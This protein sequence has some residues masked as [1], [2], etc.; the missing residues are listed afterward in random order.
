[1]CK[2]IPHISTRYCVWC[3]VQVQKS[4]MWHEW[5][6]RQHREGLTKCH[7]P[8]IP[9]LYPTS[10]R[11]SAIVVSFRGSP[12]H[13][14]THNTIFTAPTLNI[15]CMV[16]ADLPGRLGQRLQGRC[17]TW[18]GTSQWE[19]LTCM[20]VHMRDNMHMVPEAGEKCALWN[21]PNNEVGEERQK[22]LGS[23]IYSVT[24]AVWLRSVLASSSELQTGTYMYVATF[25][26][27]S[28]IIQTLPSSYVHRNYYATVALYISWQDIVRDT[29][30][31]YWHLEGLQTGLEV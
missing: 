2:T 18:S 25:L 1:M 5:F 4:I 13:Y 19:W 20:C 3:S 26:M 28:A 9:V 17:Q 6:L 24:L 31:C 22:W 11:P 27:W 12:I 21:V 8:T 7:F 10:F 16:S 29:L 15:S 14:R 23:W 30:A